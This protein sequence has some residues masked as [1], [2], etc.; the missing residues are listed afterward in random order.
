MLAQGFPSRR[1]FG[2]RRAA[3]YAQVQDAKFSVVSVRTRIQ[4]GATA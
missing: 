2:I 3:A 4:S 1:K